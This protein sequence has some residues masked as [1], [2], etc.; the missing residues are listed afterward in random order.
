MIERMSRISDKEMRFN[1]RWG[2]LSRYNGER[3][4]GVVHTET[5]QA[6][7][8]AKQWQY[9]EMTRLGLDHWDDDQPCLNCYRHHTL[10]PSG[11]PNCDRNR[12]HHAVLATGCEGFCML[13]G[14]HADSVTH[15]IERPW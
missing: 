12:Q 8:A 6:R 13:C 2:D 5:W 1:E 14:L 10:D 4:H 9:D 3:S 7:M 11:W 15:E